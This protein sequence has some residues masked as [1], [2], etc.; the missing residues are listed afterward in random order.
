MC[1]QR[2]RARLSLLKAGGGD[3]RNVVRHRVRSESTP[4]DRTRSISASIPSRSTEGRGM[5]VTRPCAP[6]GL[7]ASAG[8]HSRRRGRRALRRSSRRQASGRAFCAPPLSKSRGPNGA[9]RQLPSSWWRWSRFLATDPPQNRTPGYAPFSGS[10]TPPIK[11]A[12]NSPLEVSF[13]CQGQRRGIVSDTSSSS[14]KSAA[15]ACADHFEA[16]SASWTHLREPAN[17]GARD[18]PE[19]WIAPRW[20]PVRHQNKRLFVSGDLNSS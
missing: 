9:A 11:L 14:R 19:F 12:S 8:Y 16:A 13:C 1:Q 7:C 18:R 3:D 6:A 20:L 17:V 4:S 5:A 10:K 2:Y 15:R